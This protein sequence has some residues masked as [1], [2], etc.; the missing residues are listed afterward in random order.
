MNKTFILSTTIYLAVALISCSEKVGNPRN[1]TTDKEKIEQRDSDLTKCKTQQIPY[2]AKKIINAYPD[3]GLRYE[4][5]YIIFKD[6]TK[7]L[8]DDGRK[9]NYEERL[10]DSDIEDMFF[11]PYDRK[12]KKPAYLSDCG[13]SRCEPFYKKMYGST[14]QEV[15][16]NL[17][18]IDWF[19][20]KLKITKVNG[21]NKQLTKVAKDLAFIP[22]HKAFFKS[23][24]TF[25]WRQVRG[26]NRLSAHSYGIAIDIALGKSDYWLWTNPKAKETDKIHYANQIPLDIVKAF[27]KHGFIWGGR[28][29]HYDT[30]HFEYRP[31]LLL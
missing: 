27:E 9:K 15:Q 11:V 23:A 12:S 10:D 13:R 8:F 29:Y 28:W 14:S 2:K 6:G 7:I 16:K 5:N 17:V 31:E 19:G 18:I 30:M 4:N 25:Y 20:Q 26:A 21:A 24:G 22:H 1:D 3:Q